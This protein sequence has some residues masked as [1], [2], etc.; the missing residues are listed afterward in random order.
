MIP[1]LMKFS[2]SSI[3]QKLIFLTTYLLQLMKVINIPKTQPH[4]LIYINE[5]YAQYVSFVNNCQMCKF[6]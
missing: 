5:I 2:I 3:L 6:F 1:I 4:I